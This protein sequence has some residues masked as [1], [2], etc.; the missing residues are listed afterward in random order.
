MKSLL[1][2]WCFSVMA[3][4]LI[5]MA[6]ALTVQAAE[7]MYVSVETAMAYEDRSTD[8]DV[9]AVFYGGNQIL[10]E[11]FRDNWCG[12]LVE[13]PDGDGQ[14]IAW[15]HADNLSWQMPQSFCP[16]SFGE[17]QVVQEGNC[18]AVRL[19]MRYCQIC[20]IAEERDSGLGDHQYGDWTVTKQPTCTAEGE[21]YHTCTI[22]GATQTEIMPK[23]DHQYGDWTITK[24][25]TCTAEGEREHVCRVCQYKETQ[26]IEKLPHDYEWKIV[27]E[28]T[29]HSQGVRQRV[30]KVCGYAEA[31]EAFDPE[32]TIRSGARGEEVAR[33]QQLLADQGYLE[34][35][36]ADGIFGGKT[37]NALIA[38]QT[39]HGLTPDGVGWPQT[40]KKL[41]HDFGPWKTVEKLTR[42]SAGE[43]VR[44]CRECGFEQHENVEPAPALEFGQRGEDVS[45]VQQMLNELGYD[46]GTADGIYGQKLDAAYTELAADHEMEF[47]PGHVTAAQLDTLVNAWLERISWDTEVKECTADD[48]V[49]LS[50]SVV[51][52]EEESGEEPDD[53]MTFNWSAANPGA[54]DCR[55]QFLLLWYE[56]E[57]E[58]Q[59]EEQKKEYLIMALD[60]TQLQANGENSTEGTIYVSR[61]WGSGDLHFAA[62]AVSDQTTLKWRSNTVTIEGKQPA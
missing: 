58:L 36:E 16:H 61:E 15:I 55:L 14:E 62:L 26:K 59:T 24:Q 23:A 44:T 54:A 30:C 4:L 53:L 12:V 42:E 49:Q 17:W 22:C 28:P 50:L 43:R 19:E 1:K 51:P 20:G 8:S 9:L 48:P 34:A 35:N 21:R 7:I 5:V 40:L 37:E 46:A 3:G 39:D 52:A 10:V 27:T 41:N 13:D 25:P 45:I 33:M 31:G 11:D 57:E 47:E 32:G 38:F 6:M 2:K 18:N 29:D 60:G 56:D